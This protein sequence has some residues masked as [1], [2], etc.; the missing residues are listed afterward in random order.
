M[1]IKHLNSWKTIAIRVIEFKICTISLRALKPL[2]YG[3]KKLH[4][5]MELGTFCIHVFL[6]LCSQHFFQ[7][8]IARYNLSQNVAFLNLNFLSN[9]TPCRR[10][11]HE[12]LTGL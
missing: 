10:V 5:F 7:G 3:P 2:Y 9:Y 11:H 8:S 12:K 6:K 1:N 4:T